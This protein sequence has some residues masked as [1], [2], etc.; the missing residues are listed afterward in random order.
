MSITNPYKNAVYA[1]LYIVF[2]A[3]TINTVSTYAKHG[4]SIMI[5]IILLSLLVLSA[6]TMATLF[7]FEPLSMLIKG[8]SR[9]ALSFIGRMLGTFFVF[10]VIS[11]ASFLFY[12]M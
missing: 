3:C 10:V 6:A 12:Q 7:F 5:P 8:D 11:V 1:V 4:P 9:G 2:I